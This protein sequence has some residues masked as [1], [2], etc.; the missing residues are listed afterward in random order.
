MENSAL[1]TRGV[2]VGGAEDA[3]SGLSSCMTPYAAN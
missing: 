2:T 3:E 1:K